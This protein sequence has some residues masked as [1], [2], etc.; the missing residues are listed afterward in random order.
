MLGPGNRGKGL[1]EGPDFERLVVKKPVYEV[2]AGT[3]VKNRQEPASMTLM[4]NNLV[5]GC[6]IYIECGWVF[7]MPDP[8]PHI[9][10]HVHKFE[11]IVLHFGADHEKP[12]HLGAEIEFFLGG[13]PLKVN[14]TSAVYV[15]SGV[16]HGPLVWK[17]YQSPHLEMAIVPG[18][19]SL[20]EADPGGHQEKMKARK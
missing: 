7:G 17:K 9:F 10:E 4:S 15:P 1:S 14:K 16:K 8:N 6:N 5:P 20:D 11:E 12:E 18:A 3:P 19:G 2:I 13:Q